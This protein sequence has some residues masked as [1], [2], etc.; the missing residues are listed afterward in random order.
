MGFIRKI[1]GVTAQRKAMERQANAT[2]ESANIVANQQAAQARDAAVLAAQQ[3]AQEAQRQQVAAL[4]AQ[5]QER[6]TEFAEAPEVSL[7]AP[8]EESSGSRRRRVREQF[9]TGYVSGVQI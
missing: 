2:I 1:T 9:G 4:S 5:Q 6:A 8:D 3:R 7:Q